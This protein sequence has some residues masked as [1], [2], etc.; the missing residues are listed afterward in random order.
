VFALNKIKGD[1]REWKHER[2]RKYEMIENGHSSYPTWI[3]FKEEFLLRFSPEEF[4]DKALTRLIRLTS[5]RQKEK[6][7]INYIGDFETLISQANITNERQKLTYFSQG[8]PTRYEDSLILLGINTYEAAVAKIR[9]IKK[10]LDR[11]GVTTGHTKDPNAMD[12]DRTQINAVK[13]HTTDK[14]YYCGITGHWAK[15]CRK[16]QHAQSQGQQQQRQPA[17]STSSNGMSFSRGNYRGRGR[18][19]GSN[20]GNYRGRGQN[21]GSFQR[22]GNN[23]HIRAITNGE[24]GQEEE[25]EDDDLAFSINAALATVDNEKRDQIIAQLSQG[26][27]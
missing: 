8:L 26:F 20:R 19:R 22:R 13:A 17:Q 5:K 1:A 9:E 16:K 21:R 6:D 24:E 27:Q 15:D 2:L 25:A 14:C 4:E 10:G 23:R 7:V 11:Q 3:A 12:V 18:G